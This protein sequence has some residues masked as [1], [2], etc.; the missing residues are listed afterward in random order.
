MDELAG[1]IESRLV[2]AVAFEPPELLADQVYGLDD[3][4][5]RRIISF[6]LA[7]VDLTRPVEFS[8]LLTTDEELRVLNRDFRGRDEPTDVLSFPLLD[9]PIIEAPADELWQAAGEEELAGEDVMPSVFTDDTDAIYDGADIE[10][11]MEPGDVQP[12]ISADGEFPLHL[13]DIAISLD[14]VKRQAAHAGHSAGWELAFLLSHGVLHLV[15]YDDHTEA[16][17][18]A[19]VAHQE[20][21]LLAAGMVR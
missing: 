10:G 5:L 1:E 2:L 11:E 9:E 7:R 16:G 17:Y 20:A 12:F 19:M 4:A 18:H 3:S 13:G 8:L 14:A 21:A 15:G 6:T